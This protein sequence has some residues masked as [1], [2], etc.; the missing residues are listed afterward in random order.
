[1]IIIDLIF[2]CLYWHW[3]ESGSEGRVGRPG[4][5]WEQSQE[6]FIMP[7][8]WPKG[9]GDSQQKWIFSGKNNYLGLKNES[10]TESS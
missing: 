10:F 6:K 9:R 7:G 3:G 4:K 8:I 1:M 2:V 5:E